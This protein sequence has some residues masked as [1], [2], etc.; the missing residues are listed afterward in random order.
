MLEMSA[1]LRRD[2]TAVITTLTS[3]DPRAILQRKG[4]LFGRKEA[5]GSERLVVLSQFHSEHRVQPYKV[6][7]KHLMKGRLISW[8]DHVVGLPQEMVGAMTLIFACH[9][10]QDGGI[11]FGRKHVL[12]Q[13]ARAP[14]QDRFNC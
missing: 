2:S 8:I 9:G 4:L 11:Y 14:E 12:N 1:H 10:D 6:V 7:P 13:P 5:K 3:T